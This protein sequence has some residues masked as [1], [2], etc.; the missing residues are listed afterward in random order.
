M[1][2]IINYFQLGYCFLNLCMRIIIAITL[3]LGDHKFSVLGLGLALV[4]APALAPCQSEP[5]SM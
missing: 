4:L 3:T 5:L 1:K 2:T